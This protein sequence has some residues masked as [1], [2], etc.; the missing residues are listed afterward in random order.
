MRDCPFKRS[1]SRDPPSHGSQPVTIQSAVPPLAAPPPQA[2]SATQPAGVLP[3][4]PSAHR[5]LAIPTVI[6]CGNRRSGDPQSQAEEGEAER[7]RQ[8]EGCG[9]L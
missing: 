6:P 8:A 3:C 1:V 9:R 5:L 4:H 2:A 7:W